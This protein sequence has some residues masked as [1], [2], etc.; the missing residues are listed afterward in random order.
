MTAQLF[1]LRLAGS[2][3]A[4]DHPP[5]SRRARRPNPPPPA[6]ILRQ[7]ADLLPSAADDI[8]M[9][10][11]RGLSEWPRGGQLQLILFPHRKGLWSVGLVG[12]PGSQSGTQQVQLVR[13]R[14]HTICYAE[15]VGRW[16]TQAVRV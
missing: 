3:R 10:L 6:D 1:S 4:D 13:A 14:A 11:A 5:P 16:K 2:R 9:G 8:I 12:I 15:T 7:R